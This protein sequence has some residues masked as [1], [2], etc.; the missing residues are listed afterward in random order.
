MISSVGVFYA[1]AGRL[2]ERPASARLRGEHTQNPS[3]VLIRDVMI[4]LL[5]LVAVIFMGMALRVI[6]SGHS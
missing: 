4:V 5:L 6:L 3:P 1:K 2:R